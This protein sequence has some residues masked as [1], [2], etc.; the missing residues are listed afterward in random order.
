MIFLFVF[1]ACAEPDGAD[2]GGE[3]PCE[4]ES[5]RICRFAGDGLQALGRDDVLATESSLYLPQDITFGPDGGGYLQDWSNHRIR[6]I[7]PDGMVT[8]IAGIAF[9]GDGPEGPAEI[10]AI[11]HPTHISFGPDGRLFFAAWHNSR[12]EVIDLE[13]GML[14][15]VGGDGSRSYGGDGGDARVAQFDLPAGVAFDDDGLLYVSD[16]ANWRIRTIDGDGIIQTYAGTGEAGFAGDGGPASQAQF[17]SASGQSAAP[18]S[19][20]LID[21]NRLYLADT[22]NH[23]VRVIDLETDIITTFAGDGNPGTT[24]D[25][26]PAR[27]ARLFGPTDIAV[28][29]S[30]EFYIADSWN[31]CIR[32]VGTDGVIETFAGICG[33]PGSDGDGGP[34]TEAKLNEPAGVSVDA[35]GNV[36]IGDTYNNVFRVVYR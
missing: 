28:G 32:V 16:Q 12:V 25:G 2:S 33:V 5:G 23:R 1:G 36:Y 6:R 24:G 15:F 27:D 14:S 29:V 8:T 17:K 34:A 20:I 9:I 35:T 26:G 13:T 22:E 11:N 4:P 7:D 10:A 3:P 31:S 30:G 18:G 19:R 21:E